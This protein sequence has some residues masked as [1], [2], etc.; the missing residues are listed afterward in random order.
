MAERKSAKIKLGYESPGIDF[1]KHDTGSL[2][3][4]IEKHIK[5]LNDAIEKLQAIY[6]EI[7]DCEA[8]ISMGGHK[9]IDYIK[10]KGPTTVIDEMKAKG[11]VKYANEESDSDSDSDDEE[12]IEEVEEA[13]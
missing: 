5:L 9:D 10:I 4:D 11:L 6:D 2:L 7:Q 13:E 12:E 8:D 1:D 3:V